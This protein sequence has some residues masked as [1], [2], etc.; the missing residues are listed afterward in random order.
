MMNKKTGRRRIQRIILNREVTLT[1]I[2]GI[3]GLRR[4][5]G[6]VQYCG[7]RVEPTSKEIQGQGYYLID[8]EGFRPFQIVASGVIPIDGGIECDLI[9]WGYGSEEK[10]RHRL[11]QRYRGRINLAETPDG[12]NLEEI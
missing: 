3:P 8:S 11:H 5:Y 4:F 6:T 2:N 12:T 9:A 10:N 7:K 1:L